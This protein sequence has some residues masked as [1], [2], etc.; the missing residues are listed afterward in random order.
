MLL[1]NINSVAVDYFKRSGFHDITSMKE[2]PDSEVLEEI[3]KNV[4]ILGVRSKTKL[5]ANLLSKAKSLVAVGCFCIGHDKVDIDFANKNGIKI[6]N[7]PYANTRS[8]AEL[9]IGE[10]IML[11]RRV[12]Q[13]N[14]A[15]HNGIWEKS[16]SGC[17]EVRGKTLGIVGYGHIGAQVSILAEALGMSVIYYDVAKQLYFG[18]AKSVD[19]LEDLLRQSDVV[20]LHVPQIKGTINM[21]SKQRLDIMKD[22]AILI[23]ASRGK[24][25]NI[26]ALVE[27]LKSGKISGAAI[28]VYPEEP[29]SNK[30]KFV[31]ELQ[32]FNNV[33]LTP[34]IGGSTEEAQRNIAL[35]VSEKL[36]NY[37]LYNDSSCCCR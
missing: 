13:K 12:P 2:S 1:E 32:Q 27:S 9:V 5:D 8:V 17:F 36:V 29:A 37:Y 20:T 33:I 26:E 6:F 16:A 24:I 19:S 25:V 22:G 7:A 34:H 14:F 4:S 10:M 21:I 28:D 23:N 35:D 3:L 15:C 31:S 18:N 11:M 30:E